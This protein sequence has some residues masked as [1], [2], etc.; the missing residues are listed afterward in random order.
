MTDSA[1]VLH[2]QKR[3]KFIT[4]RSLFFGFLGIFFIAGTAKFHDNVLMGTYLIGNQLP[5]AAFFYLCLIGLGWNGMWILLDRLFK[6]EHRLSDALALSAKE[7]AVAFAMTLVACWA[8]TS[9]L[10]RYFHTQIMMPWY[11]L[12]NHQSWEVHGLLTEYLRPELFPSPWPGNPDVLSDP[13]YERVYR[14]FFTGLAKGTET[15]SILQLPLRAWIAPMLIWGPFL[16]LFAL[17]LISIQF[18]VHRQWASHEQIAYPIAQ[19][20]GQLF[21]MSD[22]RKHVP[23][24]FRNRLFWWG[25][26]PIFVLLMIEYLA[27]WFPETVPALSTFLPN[28]KGW[29]VPLYTHMPIIKKVYNYGALQWQTI[30]F[31]FV[32]IAYFVSSEVSLSVGLSYFLLAIFSIG[33]WQTTGNIIDGSVMESLRGG[34]F[35]GFFFIL[36]FTGRSYFKAVFA[37]AFGIRIRKRVKADADASQEEKDLATP[38]EVSVLAA[39]VMIV[40]FIG[41]VILFSWMCQ[42]WLIALV[43]SLLL[44]MLYTVF[45]RMVSETGIPFLQSGWSPGSLLVYLLGPAAIGPHAL[46]YILWAGN[47]ILTPDPREALI[48]YV[49]TGV[50]IADDNRLNLKKIFLWICVAALVAMVI[51]WFA[52]SWVIYNYNPTGDAWAHAYPP[53][54]PFDYS[55]R[56]FADMKAAG[57]FAASEAASPIARLGMISGSTLKT[58]YFFYG[59][60]AIILLSTIRF[61][62][63]KF[64]L[65]PILILMAGTY[66]AAAAWSSF[67]IGWFIKQL[68]VRFGGGGVYQRFKPLFIGIIAGE[69]LT[70]GLTIIVDFAYYIIVG[71]PSPVRVNF[72]PG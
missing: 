1:T 52:A 56:L 9:G 49:S 64:P 51:G 19:V 15:L 27:K 3:S 37:T 39:R 33:Y 36:A 62:F 29:W 5:P 20:T 13:A 34:A 43:F 6:A 24:I 10:C 44:F 50:K 8:P 12:S 47:T 32:G 63:A 65:H 42:S 35:T 30:F 46:T 11:F 14:G 68:I 16:T 67:L 25:V 54:T 31:T 4:I 2:A 71:S 21:Q 7:I 55:A 58:H 61:R 45:S 57:T 69:I 41:F 72:M 38:D 23:G 28:L 53:V 59:I 66:P 60:I 40:T 18:L 22:E 17:T 26:L 48:G 70:I